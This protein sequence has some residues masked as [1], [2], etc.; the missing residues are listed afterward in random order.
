MLFHVT[1]YFL[2]KQQRSQKADEFWS[3]EAAVGGRGDAAAV[4]AVRV[5]VIAPVLP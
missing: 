1:A 4:E 5:L 2:F 3:E